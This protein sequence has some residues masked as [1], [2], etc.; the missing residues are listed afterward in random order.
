MQN[1]RYNIHSYTNYSP[2]RTLQIYPNPQTIKSVDPKQK[3][4]VSQLGPPGSSGI[5]YLAGV[6]ADAFFPSL[7][8]GGSTYC[9]LYRRINFF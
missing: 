5:W 1:T 7:S 9:V 3:H 6:T 4:I 8:F 2:L